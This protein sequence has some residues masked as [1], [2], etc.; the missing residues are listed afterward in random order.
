MGDFWVFGLASF[1]HPDKGT[2]AQDQ[3]ATRRMLA[4]GYSRW[5]EGSMVSG[6]RGHHTHSFQPQP[7]SSGAGILR[8]FY[9]PSQQRH[10]GHMGAH[11]CAP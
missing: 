11:T 9:H 10:A 6:D 4:I 3:Q 2:H 5:C 7:T 1:Q 8:S